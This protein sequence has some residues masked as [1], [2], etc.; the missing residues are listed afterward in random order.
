M[1]R[2]HK[3]ALEFAKEEQVLTLP[4]NATL[5]D[6]QA[7]E[8]RLTVWYMFDADDQDE[9]PLTI[10]VVPTGGELPDTFPGVYWRTIQTAGYVFH[11]FLKIVTPRPVT[12]PNDPGASTQ[13]G[14]H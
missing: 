2:I 9:A 10:Y 13:R 4:K 5:L 14:T 11:I 6:A 12:A 1:K 3:Q 7:Q 8:N